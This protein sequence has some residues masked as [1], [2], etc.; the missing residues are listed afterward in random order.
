MI[1]MSVE[2]ALYIINQDSVKTKAHGHR[3]RDCRKMRTFD[4]VRQ[5]DIYISK[6]P[7][8]DPITRDTLMAA[9]PRT[10]DP[11]ETWPKSRHVI[12]AEAG[13][14]LLKH[15]P[16]LNEAC[17]LPVQN[18]LIAPAIPIATRYAL[19]FLSP[20]EVVVEHP[21]HARILLSGGAYVITR[22]LDLATNSFV[23]D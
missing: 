17:V 1:T 4:G 6:S 23:L 14:Y 21:Q 2:Q 16:A 10:L 22:Q 13:I 3:V 11:V 12:N 8:P 19:L 5:G 7:L 20:G 18:I 15:W 9:L